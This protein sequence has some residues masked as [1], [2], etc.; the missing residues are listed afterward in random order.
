MRPTAQKK[1]PFDVEKEREVFLDERQEFVDRN[2][3]STYVARPP[4]G[5]ILEMLE[6]FDRLLSKQPTK[7]VSKL[8]EFFKNYLALIQDKDVVVELAALIGEPQE[9]L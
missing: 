3:L 6:R 2:Q 8:K 4:K 1:A 9:E 7:N 5:P